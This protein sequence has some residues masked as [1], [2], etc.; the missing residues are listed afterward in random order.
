MFSCFATRTEEAGLTTFYCNHGSRCASQLPFPVSWRYRN[1]RLLYPSAPREERFRGEGGC[2]EEHGISG[3]HRM[4]PDPALAHLRIAAPQRIAMSK[5]T[6]TGERRENSLH[7]MTLESLQCYAHF[8]VGFAVSWT[9]YLATL[10]FVVKE[11]HPL[12]IVIQCPKMQSEFDSS[13]ISCFLRHMFR[14]LYGKVLLSH[15][16][17]DCLRLLFVMVFNHCRK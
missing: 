16:R 11:D 2:L 13:Q 12:L 9:W 17:Y 1:R 14:F 10:L 5:S 6:P 4:V 7:L 8:S 15:G 3:P